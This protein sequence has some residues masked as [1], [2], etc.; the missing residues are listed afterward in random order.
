[1]QIPLASSVIIQKRHQ[2][3]SDLEP[4]NEFWTQ[5]WVPSYRATN[6]Y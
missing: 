1:V 4:D 3:Y 6:H 2:N 5:V